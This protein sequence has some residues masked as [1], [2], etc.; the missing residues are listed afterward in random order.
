MI[1]LLGVRG[2][3]TELVE[4]TCRF[5]PT[6]IMDIRPVDEP[7]GLF[8]GRLQRPGKVVFCLTLVL[9]SMDFSF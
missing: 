7:L 6:L 2:D 1:L 8:W 3:D 5:E 9:V 4:T